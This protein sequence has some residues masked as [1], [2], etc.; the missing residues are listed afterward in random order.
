MQ[1]AP[2]GQI[3]VTADRREACVH[4]AGEIDLIVAPQLALAIVDAADRAPRCW[5]DLVEVTFIDLIGLHL[6]VDAH[7]EAVARERCLLIAPPADPE[8]LRPFAPLGLVKRMPLTDR[9]SGKPPRWPRRHRETR[10]PISA[11][12]AEATAR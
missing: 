6:L 10:A 4:C 2:T 1:T 8:V 3:T 7:S 12:C 5:I 9:P 11:A